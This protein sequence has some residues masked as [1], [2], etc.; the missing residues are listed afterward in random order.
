MLS[1]TVINLLKTF[2][3]TSVEVSLFRSLAGTQPQLD[4]LLS[5]S[6]FPLIS[7]FQEAASCCPVFF[8]WRSLEFNSADSAHV[9]VNILV[10][11]ILLKVEKNGYYRE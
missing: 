1:Y 8:F 6:K 3:P 4:V 5:R 2:S 9:G 11:A 10:L 7:D